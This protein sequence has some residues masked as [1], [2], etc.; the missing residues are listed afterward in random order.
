MIDAFASMVSFRSGLLI[1]VLLS[2]GRAALPPPSGGAPHGE[3]WL[4]PEQV[5]QTQI[6]VAP[7]EVR[8]FEERIVTGGRIT[9]DDLRV[10][11]VFSPVTGRVSRIVADLG[12]QVK[13]GGPLAEIE[14]PDLASAFSDLL[15]AN[16]DLVAADHDVKRQRELAEVHA[17][18]QSQLEQSED[19]F[20]K[21]RAEMERA[22][23]KTTLLHAKDGQSVLQSYVLRSPIAGKVVARNVTPGIEVQ[24]MLSGAN[25]SNE[26][27]TVGD[28]DEVWLL[29]DLYESQLGKVRPGDK[30]EL[31]TVAYPEPFHGVVDFVSDMLDPT[32]RTSHLRC[33][34]ENPDRKLK[35]EMFVTAIVQLGERQAIAVPRTA[36]L[37]LSDQYVVF[38]QVG[39]T[40]SGLLRFT[41]RPV[42]IGDDEGGFVEIL[43]GL[44]AGDQL[45]TEGA[46]L[47][48]SQV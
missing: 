40:E 2:C 41:V 8:P 47:L 21:A 16:A 14:S 36:V 26:L 19:N 46:I 43:E 13:K 24:G 11:H 30:V 10:A 48:S 29:A 45:V 3:I 6:K 18:A 12:A 42:K 5:R 7:V 20:G 1:L 44:K 31:T 17:A 4:S 23:L 37:K 34:V 25:I 33:S 39:T 38:V 9:F 35:P 32:T 28:I 27:F 15:K 22:R